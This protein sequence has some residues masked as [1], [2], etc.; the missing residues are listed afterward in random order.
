MFQSEVVYEAGRR[1]HRENALKIGLLEVKLRR[2]GFKDSEVGRALRDQLDDQRRLEDDI[3]VFERLKSGDLDA[4]PSGRGIGRTLIALRIALGM[5]QKDLS[6][7][8]GVSEQQ[9]VRDE[10][11]HYR[12]ISVSSAKR[13]LETISA[14]HAQ[15]LDVSRLTSMS[16][17]SRSSAPFNQARML[18]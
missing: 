15:A 13:I 8:L 10:R 5:S 6:H 18:H 16:E 9:V 7:V 14:L 11:S 1:R 3:R 2:M 12:G 4:V 17:L